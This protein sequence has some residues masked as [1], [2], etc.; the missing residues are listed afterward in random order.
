MNPL[1][2]PPSVGLKLPMTASFSFHAQGA[3]PS[4]VGVKNIF[5]KVR[6]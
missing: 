6:L 2:I 3:T 5:V 4:S 1:P